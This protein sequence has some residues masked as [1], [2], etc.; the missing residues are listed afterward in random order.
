[1]DAIETFNIKNVN[2][3]LLAIGLP[4]CCRDKWTTGTV[5]TQCCGNA[6]G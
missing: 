1:M 4:F 2:N 5:T 6:W 3:Y